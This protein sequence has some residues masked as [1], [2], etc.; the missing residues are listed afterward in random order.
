VTKCC[1]L[2]DLANT[3][4]KGGSRF[5]SDSVLA[6]F[7][8]FLTYHIHRVSKKWYTKLISIT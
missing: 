2:K 4:R 1:I 8:N 7:K 5:Y 6:F 3:A